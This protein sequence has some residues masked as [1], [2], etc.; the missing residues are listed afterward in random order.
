MNEPKRWIDDPNFGALLRECIDA[1]PSLDSAIEPLPRDVRESVQR[2]LTLELLSLPLAAAQGTGLLRELSAGASELSSGTTASSAG[3]VGTTSGGLA[4]NAVQVGTTGV[5]TGLSGAGTAVSGA[6]G[7][8]GSGGATLS[9]SA[10]TSAF[11]AS[12]GA[13]VSS[14]GVAAS[15][16]GL[17]SGAKGALVL[18]IL[19]VGGSGAGYA[20]HRSEAIQENNLRSAPLPE[21]AMVAKSTSASSEPALA[22]GSGGLPLPPPRSRSSSLEQFEER[23]P[24]GATTEPAAPVPS[25]RSSPSSTKFQ[26]AP[27]GTLQT[28]DRQADSRKLVP[29]PPE[30]QTKN[31]TDSTSHGDLTLEISLLRQ[32]REAL[33]TEPARA[34]VLL[35]RYNQRFPQGLLRSEYAAL[36]R[37]LEQ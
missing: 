6:V 13:S 25:K 14:A 34:Q 15:T 20:I 26:V 12:G 31:Q 33:P 35:A 16:L 8:G 24:L 29:E 5:G 21:P 18:G 28:P 30:P 32:V 9:G 27:L 7:S 1:D 17:L 37:R 3:G 11:A 4:G 19:L 23:T 36:L 10:L 2:Q 22:H